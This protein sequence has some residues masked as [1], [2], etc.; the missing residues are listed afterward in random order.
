MPEEASSRESFLWNLLL[1]NGIWRLCKCWLSVYVTVK[2][3][4]EGTKEC[5]SPKHAMKISIVVK[6]YQQCVCRKGDFGWKK[7]HAFELCQCWKVR[8]GQPHSRY[9]FWCDLPFVKRQ[10]VLDT[11]WNDTEQTIFPAS[12]AMNQM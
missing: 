10:V 11:F 6:S 2:V 9:D 4:I 8:I 5:S 12:L 3:W 1:I 7:I